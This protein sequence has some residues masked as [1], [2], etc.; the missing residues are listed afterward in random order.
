MNKNDY[1]LVIV[2]LFISLVVALIL[3]QP[4]N[5]TVVNVYY[6]NKVIK[7]ASLKEDSTFVV[8]GKLGKVT[9]EIKDS[10]VRI[11]DETSPNNICQKQGHIS[12]VKEQLICLPNKIIVTI[13]GETEL[14]A[15]VK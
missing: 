7:T 10:K 8:D 6:E 3:K 4:N 11:I 2:T 1:T 5:P 12:K 13:D 9:I 14:D 15:V